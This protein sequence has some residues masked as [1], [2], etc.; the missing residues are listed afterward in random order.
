MGAH[1]EWRE[2]RARAARLGVDGEPV[3]VIPPDDDEF[4]SIPVL[5]LVGKELQRDDG[6]GRATARLDGGFVVIDYP[7][8]GRFVRMHVRS[9]GWVRV[10]RRGV[11]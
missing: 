9:D 8:L 2:A 6:G 4:V 1:A 7:D 3:I 5:D 11:S 10:R